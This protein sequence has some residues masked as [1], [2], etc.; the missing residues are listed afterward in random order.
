MPLPSPRLTSTTAQSG[1]CWRVSAMA[2]ATLSAAATTV[3]SSLASKARRMPCRVRAWSSTSSTLI[4]IGT[5]FEQRLDADPAA[6]PGLDGEGAPQSGQNGPDLGEVV[7]VYAA[8]V[9]HHERSRRRVDGE[10]DPQV[11]GVS[12][13]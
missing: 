12:A 1:S 2:C 10:C 9:L 13:L 11:V 5:S 7:A 3:R 6:G 4:G 8:V